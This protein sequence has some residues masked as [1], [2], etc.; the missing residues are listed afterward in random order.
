MEVF[1]S[2]IRQLLPVLGS[3]LLVPIAQPEATRQS[4]GTFL[5]NERC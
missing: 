5:S 3:E 2:H 4:G 1:L